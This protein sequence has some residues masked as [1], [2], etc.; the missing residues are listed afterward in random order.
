MLKIGTN[1]EFLNIQFRYESLK[2]YVDRLAANR[3]LAKTSLPVGRFVQSDLQT[4][5]YARR[6]PDVRE[7]DI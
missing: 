7:L 4:Q 6:I 5:R 3:S 2:R 1:L